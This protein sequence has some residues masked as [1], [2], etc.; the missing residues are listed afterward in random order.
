[1]SAAKKPAKKPANKSAKSVKKPAKD[2]GSAPRPGAQTPAPDGQTP[3]SAQVKGTGKRRRISEKRER[4][5][6]AL[7][8]E[9]R[10]LRAA[11]AQIVEGYEVRVGGRLNDMLRTLEGDDSLDQ[12]PR[13]LTT[14]QA[15]AALDEIAHVQL[16]PDKPRLRDLRR[17]QR[18]TR[19]LRRRIP[20]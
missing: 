20:E 13:H 14:A 16:R 17:I 19:K 4:V 6:A 3:D 12:P 5:N 2:T 8:V 7:H 9:L 1:M 18:L 15:Q 11:V 10:G